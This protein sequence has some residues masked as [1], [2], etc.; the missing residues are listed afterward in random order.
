MK[1][2]PKPWKERGACAECYRT[3][4]CGTSSIAS[5]PS[6]GCTVKMLMIA[7]GIIRSRPLLCN[8]CRIEIVLTLLFK[9]CTEKGS[10]QPWDRIALCIPAVSMVL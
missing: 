7:R 4:I 1:Y 2:A 6:T 8:V 10:G 9:L 3:A 5:L